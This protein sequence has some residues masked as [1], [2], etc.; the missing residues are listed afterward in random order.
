MTSL[1]QQFLTEEKAILGTAFSSMSN[2]PRHFVGIMVY[3]DHD[4]STLNKVAVQSLRRLA[5]HYLLEK[6][7]K[8]K[9]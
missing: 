8:T 7:E 1:C 4:T 3:N 5:W 9:Y 6:H 2:V